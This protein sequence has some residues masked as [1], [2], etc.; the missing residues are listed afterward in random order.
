MAQTLPVS[1]SVYEMPDLS[2]IVT[3][4]D[5]PVDNL[6]S[7]KQQRL[8]VE[9]LYT[10]WNPGRQFIADANVGV[11]RAVKEPPVVP[12]MFLSLDVRPGEDI[13]LKENRSYF[14]WKYGKPPEAVIEVVSNTEGNEKG[15]KFGTYGRIGVPYYIIFDPLCLIQP[16]PLRIHGLRKGCYLLRDNPYFPEIGLGIKLWDG[17]FE[18]L[19]EQWLRWTDLNGIPVPTGSEAFGQTQRQFEQERRRAEQEYRRAER[20]AEKLRALG[21]EPD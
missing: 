15:K 18:G 1:A 14:V 10:S 20:L 9:P 21:I 17:L 8:L 4:D 11:F 19:Y 3:E 2:H 6:F 16:V 12:D 7:A 5:T 13:W